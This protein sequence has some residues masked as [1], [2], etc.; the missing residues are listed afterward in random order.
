[1]FGRHE[2]AAF[3][4]SERADEPKKDGE[5]ENNRFASTPITDYP[6]LETISAA[7]PHLLGSGG[8]K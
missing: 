5:A 1:L 2:Q 3:L 4:S 6:R 8:A 7:L